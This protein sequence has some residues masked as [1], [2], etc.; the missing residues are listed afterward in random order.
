MGRGIGREAQT[1]IFTQGISGTTPKVPTDPLRLEAAARKALSDEAFAYIAG[2]A[3]SQRTVAANREAFRRWQ[4]WPRV[5]RDVSA[6]DLSTMFLG[7]SL[8]APLLLAP[9]GGNGTRGSRR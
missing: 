2:G 8:P 4:V 7:E 3:G 5:L 1:A 6:R 9:L